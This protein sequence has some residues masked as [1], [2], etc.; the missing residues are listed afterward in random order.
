MFSGCTVAKCECSPGCR[1][2]AD[3]GHR[4]SLAHDPERTEERRALMSQRGR[5]GQAKKN[6][7]RQAARDATASKLG[8]RSDD[9]QLTALETA[10]RSLLRSKLDAAKVA[11]A[12]AQ[13]VKVA[14]EVLHGGLEDKAERLAK[15]LADNP[16]LAARLQVVK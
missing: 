10:L 5:A 14:R 13:L 2:G 16:T 3:E 1:F 7:N 11:G 6:A 4:F 9:D 8:L 15:L 12:V